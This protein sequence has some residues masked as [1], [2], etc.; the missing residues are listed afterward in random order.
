MPYDLDPHRHVKIWLSQNQ[1][2]FLNQENQLR[3]VQMRTTNPGDVIHLVYAKQLLSPLALVELE[4]FCKKHKINPVPIEEQVLPHCLGDQDE[5]NLAELYQQE[6]NALNQGGNVAAA[7]DML[8]W[9]KPVYSL[10][11]YSDFDVKIN[12]QKLS[13][14][15][16]VDATIITKIGSV[17]TPIQGL[18][19]NDL[20]TIVLNNDSIAVAGNDLLTHQTIQKIQ[21]KIYD[22]YHNPLVYTELH[23]T[24]FR[25]VRMYVNSQLHDANAGVDVAAQ[26]LTSVSNKHLD[27]E[28][29]GGLGLINP[30]PI[31][32]RK[33]ILERSIPIYF[34]NN[35]ITT[36]EM[37]R[38]QLTTLRQG[39]LIHKK[40]S[41]Y[42][43][44]SDKDLILTLEA[45]YHQDLIKT[46]VTRTSGPGVVMLG[47]FGRMALSA[48][49]IEK[50]IKPYS[51]QHYDL[52]DA[53]LSNNCF[54]FHTSGQDVIKKGLGEAGAV[55]D[56]SWLPDGMLVQAQREKKMNADAVTIQ[57]RYRGHK[58]RK[59]LA[60]KQL[61]QGEAKASSYESSFFSSASEAVTDPLSPIVETPNKK[62][63][64]DEPNL[65]TP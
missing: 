64:K 30:N 58:I 43:A 45:E 59:T 52:N 44:M 12:T 63:K 39:S 55:C 61:P 49:V 14:I 51:F 46:S 23:D 40:L 11:I 24:L 57:R 36:K 4:S 22:A 53:F 31:T 9:L 50:E 8:R 35:P 20:E 65:S 7:S 28:L 5:H 3:L 2:I 37:L 32:L 60:K 62:V 26:V 17:K 54:A 10:G 29:A 41:Q 27:V 21:R 19:Q 48:S 38:L 34:S 16:V 15:I 6:I 13:D 47:L 42:L 1:D 25:D 18:P 56:L 33:A